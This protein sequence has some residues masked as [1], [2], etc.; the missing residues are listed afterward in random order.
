MFQTT[1]QFKGGEEGGVHARGAATS[2]CLCTC[3]AA[4]M[5]DKICMHAWVVF[6]ARLVSCQPCVCTQ[7]ACAGIQ[8]VHCELLL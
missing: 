4:D 1:C 3:C 5:C 7:G 6:K 8:G 2:W